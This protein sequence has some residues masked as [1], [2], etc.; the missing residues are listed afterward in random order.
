MVTGTGTGAWAG[1]LGAISCSGLET[2]AE[3]PIRQCTLL[4]SGTHNLLIAYSSARRYQ[5]QEKWFEAKEVVVGGSCGR[6]GRADGEWRESRGK[7]SGRR[8]GKAKGEE[9]SELN[10]NRVCSWGP[11]SKVL[12]CMHYPSINENKIQGPHA[13]LLG[14]RK[15][16]GHNIFQVG[17]PRSTHWYL[18]THLK[19]TVRVRTPPPAGT[20]EMSSSTPL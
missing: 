5:S 17:V 15:P 4:S 20:S 18:T 9:K 14:H 10:E 6:E 13:C 3:R 19:L 7:R 1:F 12:P 8:E 11:L 2:G 16:R